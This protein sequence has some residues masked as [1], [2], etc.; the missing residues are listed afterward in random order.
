MKRALIIL[1]LLGFLSP[2]L[3]QE[4]DEVEGEVIFGPQYLAD[5]DNRDSKKF[6]EYREVPNGLVLELFDFHWRPSEKGF[7]DL[8]VRDVSQ[9]DQKIVLDVGRQDLWSASVHWFENPR[10]WTDQAFQLFANSSPGTFTLEDS[11]QSAVR[12]A[13][14][15]VDANG[16]LE[17]DPGTKGFI[18]KN[19]IAQGAQPVVVSHHREDGERCSGTHPTATGSS[20]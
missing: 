17:W 1:A 12:A 3:A 19:G 18:I 13:P 6:E 15:S 2:T 4:D 5:S 7:F 10:E 8:F 11:L 14:N 20:L 9:Q 16:D